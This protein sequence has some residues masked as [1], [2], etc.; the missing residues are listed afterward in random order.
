MRGVCASENT[1][2]KPYINERISLKK[3][4]VTAGSWVLLNYA[5][6]LILR[7]SSNLILTRLLAPDVF[8]IM[9]VASVFQIVVALL[10]DLGIRQAIIQSPNGEKEQFLD[11]AWT[12]QAIRGMLIWGACVV[13]AFALHLAQI[14]GWFTQDNVY[15]NANLPPIIAAV[16]FTSVIAGFHSMK[17]IVLDRRL[18]LRRT[19]YIELIQMLAGL[20][21][22]VGLGWATRSVWAFV[23]SGITGSLVTVLLS[24]Y[25]LPGRKDRFAWKREAVV[26]LIRFGRW[27]LLSSAIGVMAMNGDRLMLA[28]W[29]TPVVLGYY[30]IA[31]NLATVVDGTANRIFGSVSLPALSEIARHDPHRLPEVY[32]RMRWLSDSLFLLVAGFLFAAAG[33]IVNSL[34]DARYGPAG[35]M[36]R[37]LSLSLIFSRFGLAQNAYVAIGRPSYVTFINVVKVFSLFTIVPILFYL[38]GIQ[39]AIVGIAIQLCPVVPVIFWLNQRHQLNN[40]KL[41]FAV[42]TLWPL[43]WL[44]GQLAVFVLQL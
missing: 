39:G 26:E 36:L 20:C 32:F 7:L 9:A 16:S 43:G 12:M 22:A 1:N 24:R 28:G 33:A 8:G 44:A 5:A 34:F 37:W 11:T 29:V 3:R 21:V 10:A 25:W 40:F 38:F 19:T 23:A 35:E 42:L 13:A 15:A 27:M 31:S 6:A 30:S 17:A 2:D 14:R 41:E 4:A 18:D